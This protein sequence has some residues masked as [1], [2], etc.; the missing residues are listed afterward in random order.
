VTLL[1]SKSTQHHPESDNIEIHSFTT[2]ES[3][4]KKI[5]DMS[6][7]DVAAVFHVAAVSDFEPIETRKGKI[8]STAPFTLKLNPTPKIIKDLRCLYPDSLLIGWKYEAEGTPDSIRARGQEQ[9]GQCRTDGCVLNGPAY[10]AGYGLL[11]ESV[12]HCRNEYDLFE[13]L[14]TLLQ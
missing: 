9:I 7:T 1:L 13:R 12:D 6:K 3:L 2:A 5:I 11:Q 8:D 10:G 4:K 14:I